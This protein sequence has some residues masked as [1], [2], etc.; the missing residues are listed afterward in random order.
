MSSPLSFLSSTPMRVEWIDSDHYVTAIGCNLAIA[1]LSNPDK[2]E[3][4]E[5]HSQPITA[6]ALDKNRKIIASGQNGKE[7][8]TE[9]ST[10]VI[11]WDI[12]SRSQI[13]I[14]RGHKSA[15]KD[16]AISEDA[17]IV[18]VTDQVTNRISIWDVQEQDLGC[19]LQT[20]KPPS[21]I[22]FGGCFKDS[23]L[24]HVTCQ[25]TLL[26]YTIKFDIRTFEYKSEFKEYANPTNGYRRT[27]DTSFFIFPY[28][29][30]G[31]HAGELA[32]YNAQTATL[33]STI[34]VDEFPISSICEGPELGTVIVAGHDLNLVK[35]DENNLSVMKTMKLE[36][37]VSSVSRLDKRAL[38]RTT[39]TSIELVDLRR[40]YRD[41]IYTG[42]VS[43][44][45]CV[46]ATKESAAIGLGDYGLTITSINKGTLKFLRYS[47][48]IRATSV[49]STPKD[50]FVIGCID[51]TVAEVDKTGSE[52]WTTEHVHRGKITAICATAEFIATGGE[53][54]MI[55]ILTHMSRS[56][57]NEMV[58][59]NAAVLKIIPAIGFP[60]RIHSVSADRT[61]T[62]TD[63]SNGKRICQQITPGRIGFTSIDQLAD[64]ETE[65]LV[66][67]GDGS[68][69]AYDWPRKGVI[70]ETESPQKLQINTI[71]LQPGS[72][73][74]A[75]GGES[76]Y[77]SFC[78]FKSEDF[79]WTLGGVAHSLP[80][81]QVTWTPDGKF[82]L[83][84]A[85]DG[86][87]LWKL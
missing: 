31:T 61:M 59:H 57:V 43:K 49:A 45:L 44:P 74:L 5:G 26:E 13:I 75:C 64:G 86:L 71:A 36:F 81:R 70:Y 47:P 85:D 60:Q 87:C 16:I 33:R 46:A 23:W 50:D 6:F 78:D 63:I 84:A 17:R 3:F 18:A 25:N 30:V 37:P 52:L 34:P 73:I 54:G 38:V 56:L 28:L 20:P 77:L 42:T 14:L 11:V 48:E 53:D 66:S 29:F 62:T 24:L 55:R 80:V 72:R 10:P 79:N 4:L 41:T 27:Y 22:V 82:L 69:R 21:S 12:A 7:S 68:I 35:V 15:I 2:Y 40:L 39:K 9:T 51:G 76:E 58:V 19:F 83:S 32:V 67:M 1:S 8:H 65:I